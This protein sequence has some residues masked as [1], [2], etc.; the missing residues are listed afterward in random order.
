MFEMKTDEQRINHIRFT[1]N[2]FYLSNANQLVQDAT[3]VET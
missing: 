2:E 3:L 1:G